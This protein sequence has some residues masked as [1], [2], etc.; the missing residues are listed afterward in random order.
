MATQHQRTLMTTMIKQIALLSLSAF[1]NSLP[2]QAL[3]EDSQQ[4]INIEADSASQKIQNNIE[5]TEYIGNVQI[6]QGSLKINGDH[7]V[8]RSEN[9]QVISMTAEGSPALFEQQSD[10]AKAPVKAKGLTLDYSLENNLVVLTGNASIQQDG[11]IVSGEKIQYNIASEQI[12]ASSDKEESSRVRM[13]LT[14]K[15]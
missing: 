3:P 11:T 4:P 15:S 9:R 6:I 14:P 8:I 7:I 5:T 13:V 2:A 10:P 12:K 1:L